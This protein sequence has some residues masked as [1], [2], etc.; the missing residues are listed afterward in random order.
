MS[1]DKAFPLGGRWIC[2]AEGK[3]RRMRGTI[4]TAFRRVKTFSFP[5]I[6]QLR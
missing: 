5:L 6:R 3:Q 4:S 1:R 2:E